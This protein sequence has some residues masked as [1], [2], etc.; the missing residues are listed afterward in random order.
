MSCGAEPSSFPPVYLLPS[1]GGVGYLIGHYVL[2]HTHSGHHQLHPRRRVFHGLHNRD[3]GGLKGAGGC[4]RLSSKRSDVEWG[5]AVSRAHLQSVQGRESSL[6]SGDG[7]GQI[8]LTLILQSF[9]LVRFNGRSLFIDTHN[10]FFGIHLCGFRLNHL[11][12]SNDPRGQCTY[13]TCRSRTTQSEEEPSSFWRCRF[14]P[15]PVWA[16]S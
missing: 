12:E 6:Q 8:V 9:G 16:V 3:V 1:P 14:L 11:K 4:Q 5:G 2:H 10:F 7:L 15:S 13:S